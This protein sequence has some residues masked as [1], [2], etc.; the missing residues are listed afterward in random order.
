MGGDPFPSCA[1]RGDTEHLK[2]TYTL[3]ERGSLCR[4]YFK[5]EDAVSVFTHLHL[6][7]QTQVQVPATVIGLPGCDRRCDRPRTRFDRVGFK[8]KLKEQEQ[9]ECIAAL[10]DAS[11][12]P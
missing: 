10:Q 4:S 11:F 2:T 9:A 3:S 12:H 6:S 1:I 5:S 8:V 7:A